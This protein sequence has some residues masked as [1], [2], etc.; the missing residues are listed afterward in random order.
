MRKNT[1]ISSKEVSWVYEAASK[2]YQERIQSIK[3][4]SH[5]KLVARWGENY[6]DRFASG[7]IKYTTDDLTLLMPLMDRFK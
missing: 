3:T 6:M 4:F 2:E 1:E 7:E 5:N